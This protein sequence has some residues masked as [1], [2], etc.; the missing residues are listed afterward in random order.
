MQS[1]G[2]TDRLPSSV[3]L[4]ERR[5]HCGPA[6]EE[7][8]ARLHFL[9]EHGCHAGLII[10]GRGL[11]K[12]WLLSRFRQA[13]AETGCEVACTDLAGIDAYELLW[14]VASQLGRDPTPD[15]PLGQLWR[16]VSDHLAENRW[17]G[18]ATVLLLDNGTSA[19][20]HVLDQVV[21]L[22]ALDP[23]GAAHL[24][25]ILTCEPK[26]LGCLGPQLVSLSALRIDL[27]PSPQSD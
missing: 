8:L 22:A 19:N 1:P 14:Q 9:V 3:P 10:G 4:E 23:A 13:L 27:T 15:Q 12:T 20:Q 24:T 16:A 11:G 18:R 6:Q 17:L 2:A 21:R 7:A 5:F 25:I 26:R